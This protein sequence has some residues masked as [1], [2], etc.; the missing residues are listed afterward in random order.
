MT[1]QS[2]YFLK[3][4]ELSDIYKYKFDNQDFFTLLLN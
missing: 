3:Y 4:I 1:I 2:E